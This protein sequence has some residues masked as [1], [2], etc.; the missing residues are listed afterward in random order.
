MDLSWE[1]NGGNFKLLVTVGPDLIDVQVI[2]ISPKRLVYHSME[3]SYILDFC[4]REVLI[5][6]EN[7]RYKFRTPFLHTTLSYYC[8]NNGVVS[9]LLIIIKAMQMT[10]SAM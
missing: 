10:W 1:L 6:W 4:D 2:Y 9:T 5:F 3:F 7:V 8:Q